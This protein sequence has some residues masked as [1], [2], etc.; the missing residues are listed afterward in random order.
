VEWVAGA[1]KV[2]YQSE[3]FRGK[4]IY[5]K[6]YGVQYGI[7]EDQTFGKVYEY[8]FDIM[9][10]RRPIMDKAIEGGWEFVEVLMKKHA[11]RGLKKGWY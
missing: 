5:Q 10:I 2:H 3:F 9:S 11:M 8:K 7:R 1:P 4:I 6:S